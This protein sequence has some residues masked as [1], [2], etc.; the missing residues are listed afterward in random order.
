M[1]RV[2]RPPGIENGFDIRVDGAVA[3][4]VR[5]IPSNQPL[6]EYDDTTRAFAR[7][8][9]EIEAGRH[10]RTLAVDVCLPAGRRDLIA[11]GARLERLARS[12]LVRP[13]P[14]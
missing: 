7:V 6:G 5:L 2:G 3:Y 13:Q 11:A 4:A 8:L 12:A 1:A 14:R 10:Q 9:D